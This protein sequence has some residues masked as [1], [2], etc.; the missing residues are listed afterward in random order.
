MSRVRLNALLLLSIVAITLF[1]IQSFAAAR[2]ISPHM[3]GLAIVAKLG[4]SKEFDDHELALA[5][6]LGAS[7]IV[8]TPG[9]WADNEKRPG[10]YRIDPEVWRV[11]SQIGAAD[12]KMILLLFRKNPLYPNPLDAQAFARY[13]G[14]MATTFRGMPVAAYQIWNEPS[15]FDF[16][17]YYGGTWN[18]R[19]YAPWVPRFAELVQ[20]AARAVRAAD[21]DATILANFEGPPL[22]NAME[23]SPQDFADLNGVSLHPYPGKLPAE[24]V[25]WGGTAI[26]LR[27]GVSVADSDGS[28]VS[29]LEIQATMDPE[30][31][32]KRPIQAWVTEY[33]FPTCDTSIHPEHFSCVS[34]ETQA[35]YHVRGLLLGLAIGVKAWAPYELSDDG[36]DL[37]D[38]EQN[39]G[40]TKSTAKHFASK[41]SYYAIQ[42]V[43]RLMG[44]DWEFTASPS[45]NLLLTGSD[46]SSD[47][48]AAS[49]VTGPQTYWFRTLHSRIAFVW[50][51]GPM[52][53][54]SQTATLRIHDSG[55][56]AKITDLVTGSTE[57]RAI[58]R[59]G[60]SDDSIDLQIGSRPIAIE[61]PN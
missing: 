36:D 13:C 43:A 50:I 56:A 30:R 12:M 29:N 41:Q 35:A 34:E 6:A 18:G 42:R 4:K 32:L 21:P 26:Y 11:A 48:T 1:N 40:L 46:T 2:D 55:E 53:N 37:S 33:G 22:I 24:Q 8:W 20:Q 49:R 54:Q 5:Q 51:A 45:A 9:E 25:P 7:V 14:W 47:K 16:R 58:V 44:S 59:K 28:L 27:D 17:E 57:T 52:S 60:H 31:Y 61:I 19:G 39:F 3:R 38:V 10:Q 23:A 15:N